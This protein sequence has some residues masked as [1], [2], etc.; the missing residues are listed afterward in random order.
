MTKQGVL[1][2]NEDN[3]SFEWIANNPNE[4][5]GKTLYLVVKGTTKKMLI[6]KN[7]LVINLHQFL[8]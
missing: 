8:M 2:V 5:S 4:F 3:E 1:K 6:I 7:I